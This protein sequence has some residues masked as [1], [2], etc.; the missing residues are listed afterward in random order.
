M[1]S[2]TEKLDHILG[3]GK[4]PCD[5]RGLGFE[6]GKETSPSKKTMFVKGLGKKEASPM[7]NHRKK[8][9]LGQCS[10]NAQVEVVSR[11]QPQAN[12][13]HH[14]AQNGKK[15]IMQVQHWK[16]DRPIQQRRMIEPTQPQR[17]GKAPKCCFISCFLICLSFI[18]FSLFFIG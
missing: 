11:R 17:Q 8:I 15:P 3:V 12:I 10:K 16:Q 18:S 1:A 5:K 7:H 6:D 2:S 13:P 14:L 9:D 4:S